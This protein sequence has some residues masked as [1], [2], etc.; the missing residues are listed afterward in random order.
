MFPGLN[1]LAPKALLNL[2]SIR[3]LFN[4]LD[5]FSD[6]GS[7]CGVSH[8]IDHRAAQPHQQQAHQQ[9]GREERGH[10]QE[11]GQGEEG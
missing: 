4:N 8:S 9:G 5:F 7:L 2:H 6:V 10:R 11:G 3:I 1:V